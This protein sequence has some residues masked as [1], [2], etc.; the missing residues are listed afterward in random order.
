M[1]VEL[2]QE[3]LQVLGAFLQRV[4][5]KGSEVPAFNQLIQKLSAAKVIEAPTEVKEPKKK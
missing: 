4:D 5:L 1:N 2:T 3:E